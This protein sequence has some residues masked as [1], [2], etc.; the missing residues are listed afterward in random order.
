MFTEMEREAEIWKE[1]YRD[2]E[3]KRRSREKENG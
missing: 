3:V 1:K 2:A